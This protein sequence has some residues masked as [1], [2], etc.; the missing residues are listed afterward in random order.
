MGSASQNPEFWISFCPHPETPRV[1]GRGHR[2]VRRQ[3]PSVASQVWC[4]PYEGRAHSLPDLPNRPP[5]G[6]PGAW[7]V[8]DAQ[9][10]CGAP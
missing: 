7:K 6:G 10:D 8:L 5:A 4:C 1:V 9:P 2:S 3:A